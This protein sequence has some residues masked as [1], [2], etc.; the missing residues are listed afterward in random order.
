MNV[1]FRD[2]ARYSSTLK[3]CNTGFPESAHFIELCD[4]ITSLAC[5]GVQIRDMELYATNALASSNYALLYSNSA[6]D[7]VVAENLHLFTGQR[8]AIWL[9]TGYGGASYVTLR[10]IEIDGAS[11]TTDLIQLN[12]GPSIVG[13]YDTV[14]AKERAASEREFTSRAASLSRQFSLRAAVARS[15]CRHSRRYNWPRRSAQRNG[16]CFLHQ[17]PDLVGNQQVRKF[18]IG[19][20][21]PNGST[22]SVFD[23]QS[24]GTSNIG[25]IVTDTTF[26]P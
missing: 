17:P 5:F 10:N 15:F 2:S 23:G 13:I 16:Q 4:K 9:E 7:G 11:S 22:R 19:R 25:T 8:G 18:V 12:Y 6:Q 24:G 14:V 3:M 1:T 20:A 21:T 26:N